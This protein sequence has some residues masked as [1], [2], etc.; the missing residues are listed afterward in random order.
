MRGHVIL[1]ASPSPDKDNV[2]QPQTIQCQVLDW[3]SRR[4]KRV[5]RSTFAAELHSMLDAAEHSKLIGLAYHEVYNPGM[6]ASQLAIALE[7]GKLMLSIDIFTD[8]RSIYDA[9]AASDLRIPTEAGL[10]PL[11][12]IILHL[13]RIGLVSKLYWVDTRDMLA[14]GLNKGAVAR[15][16]LLFTPASSQWPIQYVAKWCCKYAATAT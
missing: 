11:L 16:A 1:L 8:C 10:Y 14:D 4:Q 5:V 2:A 15:A 12:L 9:L 13:L 6:N 3:A 7:E